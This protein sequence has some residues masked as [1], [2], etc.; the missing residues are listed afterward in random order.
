Q[1]NKNW[2]TVVTNVIGVHNILNVSSCILMLAKL[3]FDIEDVIETVKT[4][5][6]VK[7]RQEV[8]GE[9][10]G[11]VVI[12]DFAHHPRAITLTIQAVRM[13]FPE[14]K[15]FTIF[16]PIS[17][18]SRSDIFQKEFSQSLQ[19]SDKVLIARNP[20]NTSVKGHNN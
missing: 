13:M 6:M 7:R 17:A 11:A 8:R 18:T 3:G 15:I 9:Y 10:K 12:D 5:K 4:L 1:V 16:E 20:L 14:K 2:H 19:L